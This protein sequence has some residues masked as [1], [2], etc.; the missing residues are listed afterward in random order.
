M[1]FAIYMSSDNS[2]GSSIKFGSY[3]T[4]G[5]KDGEE[6]SL[7]RTNKND[8]WVLKAKDFRFGANKAENINGTR[9]VFIEPSSPFIYAPA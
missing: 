7:I 3:D 4:E 8:S 2:T 5:I 6:L 9:K 1:T